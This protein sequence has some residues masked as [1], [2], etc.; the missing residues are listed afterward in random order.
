VELRKDPDDFNLRLSRRIIVGK[1]ATTCELCG[2]DEIKDMIDM[3]IVNKIRNPNNPLYQAAIAQGSIG[4]IL[5][6][7]PGCGKTALVAATAKLE[8]IQLVEVVLS[9]ILNMWSGE[10]E[11]RITRIFETVKDIARSGKPVVLFIDELDALGIAR[12]VTV[13]SVEGSWS[14][15]LRS[16]FRRLFGK[17]ENIPNLAIVGATNYIWSVDNA[18][19]REGRLGTCIIYVPPPDAKAREE[20]FRLYS[21]ETPGYETVDFKRLAEISQWFSPA[22]IKKVCKKVHFALAR[23]INKGTQKDAVACAEDYERYLRAE[24]PTTLSWIRSVAK[25]WVEGTIRDDELDP[26]L[27]DHID[28]VDPSARIKREEEKHTEERDRSFRPEYLK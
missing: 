3:L 2:L 15:D 7:P 1:I 16:T 14:R 22:D 18:L 11:K 13:E 24:V 20:I 27:L 5:H 12:S 9:E 4:I 10:S 8:G 23:R 28:L 6:G 19:K 17:V 25:A 26:K 21:R